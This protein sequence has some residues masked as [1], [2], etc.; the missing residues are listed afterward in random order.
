MKLRELMQLVNAISFS[1]SPPKSSS[2]KTSDGD[3]SEETSKEIRRWRLECLSMTTEIMNTVETVLKNRHL[4]QFYARNTPLPRHA[5]QSEEAIP[6]LNAMDPLVH[7]QSLR[8]H[9][10]CTDDLGIQLLERVNMVNKLQEFIFSYNSLLILAS[11]PLP[12]PLVQMGRAFL[13]LWTFSMPLVL[14]G[15]PFSQVWGAQIFLFFLTYGFIGLE[16]VS[17]KLSEPFGNSRDDVQ[18]S[19]IR[20]AALLGIE[21]DLKGMDYQMTMSERRFQFAQQKYRQNRQAV[22]TSD[23]T[24]NPT[25][26][27]D[28]HAGHNLEQSYSYH[29]MAGGGNNHDF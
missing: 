22:G 2:K 4:A 15:G 23:A 24:A 16:L 19:G 10:Y 18:L 6:D 27:Q 14:L 13:F 5:Y 8:V 1:N 21:N 12:F 29:A 3:D 9:M 11:T 28:V 7:I 20:D 17:I 25:A 26:F